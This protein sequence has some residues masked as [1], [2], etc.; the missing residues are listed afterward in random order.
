M[1]WNHAT[2]RRCADADASGSIETLII[3]RA[4]DIG[5]IEVRR[6]LP[7]SQRQM[8]GP[9]IFLDQMGPK[10]FSKGQGIDVPPHP[11]IGLATVTYLYEGSLVHRDS[12]GFCQRIRPGEVNWMVA[13][14]GVTHSERT[15]PEVR[16][17]AKSILA[18]IQTWVA[19]PKEA[20]ECRPCFEHLHAASLPLF[21]DQGTKLRLILGEL[22]GKRTPVST[23]SPLFYADAELKA[24]ARLSVTGEYQD[25]AIYIVDGIVEV[26]GRRFEARQMLVLCP[27]KEIT[28][29]S[30]SDSRLMLLGG[31]PLEGP[32][33]I[34]W[35]FVA[36]SQTMI[37][38]A[39]QDW[40]K[41][42]WEHNGRFALPLNDNEV[43]VPLP[44]A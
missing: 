43:F 31:E 16:A 22:Y 26:A 5:G 20:E 9:F 6:V 28:I 33:Y 24:S 1:S 41:Q 17:Q 27:G 39:K 32:R 37:E 2:N 42:D 44:G 11:H 19:L 3:P 38:D 23:F 30:I 15:A 21:E 36:S 25:R 14:R 40:K 35:N 12:L 18:G 10:V 7:S 29:T 4:R 34:W 8:V 13:G